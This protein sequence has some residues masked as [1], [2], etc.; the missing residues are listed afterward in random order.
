M[1]REPK[2]VHGVWV[3]GLM[4]HDGTDYVMHKK[5]PGAVLTQFDR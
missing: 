5:G 3:N 1:I 2:G 4:V